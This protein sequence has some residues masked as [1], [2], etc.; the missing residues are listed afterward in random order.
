MAGRLV[1]GVSAAP[2][3]VV[4]SPETGMTALFALEHHLEWCVSCS[5]RF[6]EQVFHN[7]LGKHHTFVSSL[8]E[9]D[10]NA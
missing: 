5:Q 8:P 10:Y 3:K 6:G 9:D 4:R 2:E 1:W 7:A